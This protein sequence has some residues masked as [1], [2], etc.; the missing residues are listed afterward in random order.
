MHK[1]AQLAFAPQAAA[2]EID[3]A[4]ADLQNKHFLT[5]GSPRHT[6][7][8]KSKDPQ[9]ISQTRVGPAAPSGPGGEVW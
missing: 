9:L 2:V 5:E 4:Q 6:V 7:K 8:S 1:F 3:D